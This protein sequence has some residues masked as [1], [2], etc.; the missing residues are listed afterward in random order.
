MVTN[1]KDEPEP[2]FLETVASNRQVHDYENEMALTAKTNRSLIHKSHNIRNVNDT[3]R[4]RLRNEHLDSYSDDD[5]R[6]VTIL[7][8]RHTSIKRT[9]TIK[10]TEKAK[11]PEHKQLWITNQGEYTN[12]RVG[13][14]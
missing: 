1:S 5:R 12:N 9:T 2:T 10:Y 3:S 4:M 7:R 11:K 14:R 13:R 6:D 8:R